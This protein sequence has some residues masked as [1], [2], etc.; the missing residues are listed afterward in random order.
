MALHLTLEKGDRVI[1]SCDV[2]IDIRRTGSQTQ[3]SIEAPKDVKIQP[4]FRDSK[5]QLN[6]GIKSHD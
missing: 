2:V 6:H 5:K 3:L 1:L 4:I